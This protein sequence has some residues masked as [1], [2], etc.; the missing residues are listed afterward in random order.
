[1]GPS[2]SF[3]HLWINL[4]ARRCKD[5]R[6]GAS[7]AHINICSRRLF[8]AVCLLHLSSDWW[9]KWQKA[10]AD[11][12]LMLFSI[13]ILISSP[14]WVSTKYAGYSKVTLAA[15]LSR[16]VSIMSSSKSFGFIN[17]PFFSARVKFLPN[18]SSR[19]LEAERRTKDKSRDWPRHTKAR[20]PQQG[21]SF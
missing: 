15:V 9:N 1:M 17:L 13:I 4:S 6:L 7:N 5:C 14:G 2:K 16:Q 3:S 19:T 18:Y 8:S 10:N 11:S 20:S 21:L 12:S